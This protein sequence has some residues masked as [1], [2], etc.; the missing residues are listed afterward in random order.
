MALFGDP[1]EPFMGECNVGHIANINENYSELIGNCDMIP[2]DEFGL[3]MTQ[4]T[5]RDVGQRILVMVGTYTPSPPGNR[6]YVIGRIIYFDMN[7]EDST[8]E[9]ETFGRDMYEQSLRTVAKTLRSSDCTP[10]PTPE[11]IG[12]FAKN[13]MRLLE[14]KIS[15]T[16]VPRRSLRTEQAVRTER[17]PEVDN[18]SADKHAKKRPRK[19]E[20]REEGKEEEREEEEEFSCMVCEDAPPTTRVEPCGHVVV[21]AKCSE[22]L[23]T[24]KRDRKECIKCRNVITAVVNLETDETDLRE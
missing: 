16:G 18:L 10:H 11:R 17:D 4:Y 19:E 1:R 14:E 2:G 20:E 23:K 24:I 15:N 5:L 22:G 9:M 12:I 3:G 7:R 6:S 21:C 8:L 13:V